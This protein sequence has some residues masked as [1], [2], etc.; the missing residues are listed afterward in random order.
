[1]IPNGGE[2]DRQR[3]ALTPRALN[4]DD[5]TP[6]PTSQTFVLQDDL[7]GRYRPERLTYADALAFA[8][9]DGF[10]TVRRLDEVLAETGR[11]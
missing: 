11:A 1:M 5:V 9:A 3:E 6:L 8:R 2:P 10:V 4:V 7:T